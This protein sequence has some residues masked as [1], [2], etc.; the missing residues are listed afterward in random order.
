MSGGQLFSA[1][2]QQASAHGR[3]GLAALVVLLLTAVYLTYAAVPLISAWNSKHDVALSPT[4]DAT[5]RARKSKFDSLL[6]GAADTIDR[7]W[8]F[9]AERKVVAN[10]PRPATPAR[11]GG[12]DLVAMVAD[13]AIFRDGKQRKVG[14]DEIDGVAVVAMD[15]PWSAR[16]RWMGAEFTVNLFERNPTLLVAGP[17]LLRPGQPVGNSAPIGTQGGATGASPGG[18]PGGLDTGAGVAEISTLSMPGGPTAGGNAKGGKGNVTTFTAN[19]PQ[20]ISGAPVMLQSSGGAMFIP[21]E[22]ADVQTFTTPD[23]TVVR[24][25]IMPAG[26]A[27]AQGV[28]VPAQGQPVPVPPPPPPP[29]DETPPKN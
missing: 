9:A 23:G 27:P 26:A 21:P 1:L 11:Y 22:G 24:R 12:P 4:D 28:P 14:G 19:G 29:P 16:V 10:T 13:V 8:P 7:R 20:V 25:V 5:L 18:R 6:S 2:K 15:P 3:L 17:G